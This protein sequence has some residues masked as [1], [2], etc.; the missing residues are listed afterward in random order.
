MR[1]LCPVGERGCLEIPR[2]I[3]K[4][5]LLPLRP[6]TPLTTG[7]RSVPSLVKPHD[8]SQPMARYY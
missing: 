4:P 5:G 6:E 3:A 2:Q 8:P 1:F 7:A